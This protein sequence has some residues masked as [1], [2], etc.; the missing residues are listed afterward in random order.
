MSIEKADIEENEPISKI[1]QLTW[2]RPSKPWE[3][4]IILKQSIF[5]KINKFMIKTSK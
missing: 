5:K 1:L 2:P 3:L 4:F